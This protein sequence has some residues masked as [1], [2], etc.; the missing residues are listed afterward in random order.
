VPTFAWT[1][2]QGT[3]GKLGTAVIESSVV[4]FQNNQINLDNLNAVA[5]VTAGGHIPVSVT[6][7]GK[8]VFGGNYCFGHYTFH[9]NHI[10]I[11]CR[12]FASALFDTKR[13]LADLNYNQQTVSQMI[14]QFAQYV[15]LPTP[16]IQISND[17]IVGTVFDAVGLT[18]GGVTYNTYPR[19]L[20]EIAQFLAKWVGAQIYTDPQG[21]IHVHDLPT[22]GT[23][24]QYQWFVD[25]QAAAADFQLPV[26]EYEVLHQPER[27]K[28]FSVIVKSHHGQRAQDYMHT[29]TVNGQSVTLSGNKTLGAGFFSANGG[30]VQA[31][32][33]L[34][35]A[36]NGIPTL[37]FRYDGLIQSEVQAKAEGIAR[38]IAKRLFVNTIKVDGDPTLKPLEQ[39]TIIEGQQ[40]TTLGFAQKQL[41]ISEVIHNFRMPENIT[42]GSGF[43][44]TIKALT[45]PPG[46]SD[47][48]PDTLAGG[49]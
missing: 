7:N 39:I 42:H 37:I 27:N 14:T 19:P 29:V 31:R 8:T 1:I 16:D 36:Q 11:T 48:D 41:Y 20:W 38:E 4:D 43:S 49:L 6:I 34:S 46:A 44:T 5:G 24:R 9:D 22:G 32:S 12:D 10:E 17:P 28:N 40:G 26:L 30:G 2:S 45:F 13:S 15:S 18:T 21:V 25:P 47:V 23:T 3:Y 35:A 33:V